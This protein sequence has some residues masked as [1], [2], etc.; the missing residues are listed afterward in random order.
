M[1]IDKNL[2]NSYFKLDKQKLKSFVEED[3]S[4]INCFIKL[5]NLLLTGKFNE[6]KDVL[7][8]GEKTFNEKIL[9]YKLDCFEL[10]NYQSHPKIKAPLSN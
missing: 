7:E 9:S 1:D 8:I 10:I 4:D 2:R 3:N 6:I 5:K